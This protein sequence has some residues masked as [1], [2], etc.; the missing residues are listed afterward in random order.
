MDIGKINKKKYDVNITRG[1]KRVGKVSVKVDVEVE[2]EVKVEVEYSLRLRL[3]LSLRSNLRLNLRL[4]L[5]LRLMLMLS[6]RLNLRLSLR[7]LAYMA[8][9]CGHFS[10]LL[11][12]GGYWSYSGQQI[13]EMVIIRKK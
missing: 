4:R 9:S 2:V 8:N 7:L 13:F 6:L 1:R 3:M 5:R 10:C 11:V 12:M